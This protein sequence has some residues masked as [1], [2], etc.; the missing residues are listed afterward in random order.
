MSFSDCMT[1]GLFKK[2]FQKNSKFTDNV[3]NESMGN[4]WDA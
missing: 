2:E 3:I 1:N 4:V